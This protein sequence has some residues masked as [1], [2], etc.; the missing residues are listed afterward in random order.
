MILYQSDLRDLRNMQQGRQEQSRQ[1]S[2]RCKVVATGAVMAISIPC[3]Y[4]KQKTKKRKTF[5]D[6]LLRVAETNGHCSL[7]SASENL[8][9]SKEESLDSQFLPAASAK[10]ILQGMRGLPELTVT[11]LVNGFCCIHSHTL[12]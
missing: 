3:L 10:K 8:V 12:I 4:T 9:S 5:N 2:N 7:Y 6:G 1:E 11:I